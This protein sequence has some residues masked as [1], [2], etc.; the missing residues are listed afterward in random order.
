[1]KKTPLCVSEASKMGMA[2]ESSWLACKMVRLLESE[3]YTLLKIQDG[4]TITNGLSNTGVETSSKHE[5]L[6]VAA[7]LCRTSYLCPSALL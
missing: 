4:M 3:N 2:S 6:D 1:M 5:M 7:S